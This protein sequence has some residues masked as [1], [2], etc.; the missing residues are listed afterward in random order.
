MSRRTSFLLSTAILSIAF[1]F[2]FGWTASTRA[3][4]VSSVV[5]GVYIN[6]DGTL[7]NATRQENAE[8]EKQMKGL[9]SIIPGGLD[10]PSPFRKVSLKMLN[11]EMQRCVRE[12]QDFTPAICFLGGLT[13]IKYVVALPEENDILLIGPAEGWKVDATGSVVGKATG[14][15]ILLLQDLITVF[16]A[17]NTDRPPIITCS[18]DPTPEAMLKTQQITRVSARQGEEKQR[19]HA[20]EQ[21]NGN[22]LVSIKGIPATSRFAKVIVA[23]DYK[24]KRIGLGQEKAPVP[25]VPS[26]IS[27]INPRTKNASIT[28]R[29]WFAPEYDTITH[30]STGLV[31]DVGS[32][33][34]KT[35][36]EDEYFDARTGRPQVS[37]RTDIAA[38]RWCEKMNA[39]F[40]K[41]TKADPVFGDLKNCM[42]IAM[43]VALIHRE[44]LLAKTNCQLPMFSDSLSLKLPTYPEPKYVPAKSVIEG[45]VIACGGVEINPFM[46]IAESKLNTQLDLLD[47]TLVAP[48][49]ETWFSNPK[50]P[51]RSVPGKR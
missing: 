12:E 1:A 46:K 36:T 16:R 13:S 45:R 49:D 28:P 48:I 37:G 27:L 31:W 24:M 26:Y 9:V 51:G 41:L 38:Q 3:Q 11:V 30:D 25:G 34:V 50:T 4:V 20:L 33:K 44:G 42:D 14:V 29:F 10:Q 40:E 32:L 15:P 17:W 19:L 2:L 39:N 6:A 43:A 8:L 7:R 47:K 21:A 5:G 18:I 23:A 35:L 22:H